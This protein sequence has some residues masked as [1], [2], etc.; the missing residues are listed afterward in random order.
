MRAVWMVKSRQ[1]GARLAWWLTLVNFDRRDRSLSH[2]LYLL[3]LVLFGLLWF[4]A[5]LSLLA[6][7]ALV[8]LQALPGASESQTAASLGALALFGWGLYLLWQVSRRSPLVFT[9][10]DA[11]LLCQAPVPPAGVTLAWYFGSWLGTAAPFWAGA[12][13][14]SIALVDSRL[15]EDVSAADLPVYMA[16][17]LRALAVV[18]LVQA[19]VL[20]LAWAVG[21]LR[22]QRDRWLVW[23]PGA[24]RGAIL[25]AALYLAY[26][27]ARSGLAGIDQGVW[28]ALLWPIA[29]PLQAAFGA[30]PYIP[31]L[32]AGL[33]LALLGLLLLALGGIHL[34][35]GR[36]AQETT[37]RALIEAARRYGQADLAQRLSLRDRLG[38]GHAPAPWPLGPGVKALAWKG[39]LQSW[40]RVGFRDL[41]NWLLLFGVGL[42]ALLATD[43]G[44]R[45][46]T[47]AVWSVMVGQRVSAGLQKDLGHWSLLRSLPFTS[48]QVIAGELAL[49]WALAVLLG[50]AAL[51][52]T[53]SLLPPDLRLTLL[54][55][56][57]C[58]SAAAALATTFDLLR[59]AR[60][61]RLLNGVPPQNG[62]SSSLLSLACLALPA[63][64][65]FWLGR[66]RID[67]SFPALLAALLLANIFWRLAQRR[68]RRI[69]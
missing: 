50:W 3:Y 35:L 59:Q 53:G 2:R 10:E 33:A 69:R 24:L 28:Q 5:A 7:P 31:G 65:W 42:G 34:N 64:L 30:A 23:Q 8:L 44:V 18:L 22:L 16:A 67:G 58:V 27:L 62:A 45:L 66:M 48:G 17:G 49:P 60:T 19:A 55:M 15:A 43:G 14:L 47:L 40:R 52:L 29:F 37:R 11:H 63:G 51:A 54:L 20:A 32:L 6:G 25:I 13:T 36:A 21:T 38:S 4:A 9:E 57:P 68:L 41:L 39:L 56:L 26:T 1:I 46:L 61:D 12:V